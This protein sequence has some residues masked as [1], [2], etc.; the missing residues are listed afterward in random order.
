MFL[1]SQSGETADTLE[2]T[3][4]AKEGASVLGIVNAVGSSIARLTDEGCYLHAG[5]EIGVAS[6]KLLHL[7]LCYFS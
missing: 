3:R 1:L 2:A 4:I 5:P 6:T 7:S